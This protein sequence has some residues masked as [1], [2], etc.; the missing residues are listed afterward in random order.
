[1]GKSTGPQDITLFV[2]QAH[3]ARAFRRHNEPTSVGEEFE[4]LCSILKQT[5]TLV[6]RNTSSVCLVLFR[7]LQSIND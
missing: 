6:F 2:E 3:L 1:M 4:H 7:F 5:A